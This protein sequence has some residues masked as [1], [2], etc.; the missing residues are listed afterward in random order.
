MAVYGYVSL[1]PTPSLPWEP[2]KSTAQPKD[3]KYVP[4]EFKA[5][6]LPQAR[7]HFWPSPSGQDGPR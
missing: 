3:G 7:G 6:P 1:C 4:K 2:G 5:V